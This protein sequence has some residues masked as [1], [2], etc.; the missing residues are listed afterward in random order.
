MDVRD[1]LTAGVLTVVFTAGGYAAVI[2]YGMR[3]LN[4]LG[5]KYHRLV[6]LLMRW[7]DTD[8]KRQQVADLM[9]GK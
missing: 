8:E 7:A 4:G 9:D 5:K 2:R 1:W 6:A 3:D